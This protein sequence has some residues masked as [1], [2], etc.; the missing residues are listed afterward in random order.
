[1][2]RPRFV[3]LTNGN[4]FA[5]LILEGLISRYAD[6]ICGIVV[7]TGDYKGRTGL[8]SLW[9]VG[10]TTALPYL[11]YK[12]FTTVFF[13]LAQLWAPGVA[14]SVEQQAKQKGIPIQQAIS[15]KSP[16][17]LARIESQQPDLIVSV[18][19]PQLI[20][21]RIL[22]SAR[23]GGINIH[24]SLLPAYAGLAPYYWVL[25]VGE[26]ETGTTVH[27]MT[28]RFDEGNILVQKRT[29]IE[30]GES[31][32]HLFRRLALLGRDALMEGA[33]LALAGSEGTRQDLTGYT[34]FS[35]P[36]FRSH[37]SLRRNG[38]VLVRVSE[39]L[40]TLGADLPDQRFPQTRNQYDGA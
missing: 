38:H 37:L 19:C 16:D 13:K 27:Y 28:Q 31:A 2:D 7:V 1:M 6:D 20:G 8:N 32:F 9:E 4:Y 26:R 18:S 23:L 3:V 11:L 17:V 10:R 12:V 30:P 5:R 21:K 24:S 29:P 40:E 14:F 39:L 35:N 22:S 33:E 25:S 34:Y 15:V 36:T